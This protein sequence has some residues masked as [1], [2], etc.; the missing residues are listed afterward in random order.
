MP[1]ESLCKFNIITYD[2][3]PNISIVVQIKNDEKRVALV[4]R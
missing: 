4:R 3:N 2:T 1:L